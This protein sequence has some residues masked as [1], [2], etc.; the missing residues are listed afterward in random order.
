MACTKKISTCE[1]K[2]EIHPNIFLSNITRQYL[3]LIE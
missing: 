2:T 3:F 1:K